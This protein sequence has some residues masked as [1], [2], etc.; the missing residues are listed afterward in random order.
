MVQGFECDRRQGL[1]VGQKVVA[2]CEKL[3]ELLRSDGRSGEENP[4]H[5]VNVVGH[6]VDQQVG[7]LS[8][9]GV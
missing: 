3:V 7:W 4:K 9:R 1:L 2:H 8:H 5:E 6:L